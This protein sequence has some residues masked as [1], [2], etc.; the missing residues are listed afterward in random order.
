MRAAAADDTGLFIEAYPG[1]GK[2]T[3]ASE[4]FGA[5]RFHRLARSDHRAVVATSFTKAATFEVQQRILR[6]WGARSLTWPHRVVTVDSLLRELLEWLLAVRHVEWPGGCTA[7]VVRDSWRGLVPT[8]GR[9]SIPR[10]R[11]HDRRVHVWSE[12]VEK[13]RSAPLLADF[14]ASLKVGHCT[15]DEVRTILAAALADDE[16]RD[17][18]RD[19]LAATIRGLIIDEVFD[20]NALDV[21]LIELCLDAGVAITMIGDPW[22]ALYEFRGATP[23]EVRGLT[24]RSDVSAKSLSDS[25]RWK[26]Q[27]QRDLAATLRARGRAGVPED[28]KAQVSIV[29]AAQWKWLW[30][31]TSRVLPTAFGSARHDLAYAGATVVLSQATKAAFGLSATFVQ[32]ARATLGIESPKLAVAV[33]HWADSLIERL[34]GDHTYDHKRA[35]IDMATELGA[36]VDAKFPAA[37]HTREA[38]FKWMKPRLT[39]TIQLVPGITVHQ[40]KGREWPRVGLVLSSHQT[41]ALAEGLDPDRSEHRLLYVACT[42]AQWSTTQIG[43]A[44]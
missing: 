27:E 6:T 24:A 7:L 19:R 17:A 4:R 20:A 43:S 23:D 11:L 3:V 13:H 10:V 25:F 15:H 36:L 38:Y 9:R 37:H 34:A 16:L 29:L 39:S 12:R 22:Q 5:L 2:T 28:H 33:E 40:A 18:L 31:A 35:Y 1:S 41:D 8:K 21:S 30:E 42:R 14:N 32:D 26:S 44:P